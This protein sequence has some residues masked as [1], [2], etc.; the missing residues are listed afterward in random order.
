MKNNFYTIHK[1]KFSLT[2]EA[3]EKLDNYRLDIKQHFSGKDSEEV[4]FDMDLALIDKLETISESKQNDKTIEL[5]DIEKIINQLGSIEEITEDTSEIKQE[6]IMTG[7]KLFRT[8]EDSLIAGVCSGLAIYMGIPVWGLRAI[9]IL[10]IFTPFPII[11]SY[12]I[13]WYVVPQAQNKSDELQMHGVPVNLSSLTNTKGYTHKKVMSL[14]KIAAIAFVIL[15]LVIVTVVSI[16][17]FLS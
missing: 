10:A 4:I 6:I 14:A 7:K 12:L 13:L 2:T 5:S 3:Q 9:F 15:A 8:Q 16:N 11:I 1:E 17:I